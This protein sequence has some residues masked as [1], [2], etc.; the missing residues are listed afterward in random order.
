MRTKCIRSTARHM[1]GT[2]SAPAT[3][4]ATASECVCWYKHITNTV[5]RILI[6]RLPPPARKQICCVRSCRLSLIAVD[7]G[8]GGGAGVGATCAR[9]AGGWAGASAHQVRQ[10]GWPKIS[11]PYGQCDAQ[12]RFDGGTC[13]PHNVPYDCTAALSEMKCAD[14]VARSSV[15]VVATELPL[16]LCICWRLSCWRE[17]VSTLWI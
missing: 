11:S 5:R 6:K 1:C 16:V 13:A 2:L 10:P 14:M 8:A 7:D 3:A 17:C 9:A 15:A 12:R 4:T